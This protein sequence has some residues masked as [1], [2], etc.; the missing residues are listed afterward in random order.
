VTIQELQTKTKFA[1]TLDVNS[2]DTISNLLTITP[3][4]KP[5]YRIVNEWYSINDCIAT[6]MITSLAAVTYPVFPLEASESEREFALLNLQWTSPRIHLNFYLDVAGQSRAFIK[7][8]GLLSPKPYP[9][10][11]IIIPDFNLGDNAM[12][13]VGIQNVGFGLLQGSDKVVITGE[14][15]KHLW[16]EKT[17][18]ASAKITNTITTTASKIINEN[19]D[20]R[21]ITIFNSS[22]KNIFIDTVPG[23]SIT[24][25]MIKL[26]PGDY[27]E[28][29]APTYTGSYWAVCELGTASIDIR[30]F[31]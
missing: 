1:K 28:S 29:A 14:L 11:D 12:I 27:Y 20:R 25:Y 3:F 23:M 18:D 9:Y 13:A 2:S 8:Y 15:T 26:E 21:G 17:S 10:A 6:N 31:V 7:A 5:G 30:E 19:I 22:A 4:S 16:I 24:S